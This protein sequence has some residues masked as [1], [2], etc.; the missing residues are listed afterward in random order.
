ME[1][2]LRKIL[3]IFLFFIS[4]MMNSENKPVRLNI[5]LNDSITKEDQWLYW[6]SENVL[7]DSF[8]V[9]KGQKLLELNGELTFEEGYVSMLIFE[10]NGP[11]SMLV[12]NHGDNI[13]VDF[14]KEVLALIPYT[15]NSVTRELYEY[16][17]HIRPLNICI[18]RIKD[19]LDK[20]PDQGWARDS[21]NYYITQRKDLSIDLLKMTKNPQIYVVYMDNAVGLDRDSLVSVLKE[22]FPDS[23]IAQQY[24]EYPQEYKDIVKT[25]KSFG[26]RLNEINT[27]KKNRS[28]RPTTQKQADN[29]TK[30]NKIK[31]GD[32]I[33]NIVLNDIKE[34]PVS[35]ED[36]K[37]PYILIDFWAAWCAPCRREIPHL[38][39]VYD[40]FKEKLTIYAISLD[41]TKQIWENTILSDKCEMFTHVYGGNMTTLEGKDICNRFG[42]TA[43]PANFLL[44]NDRKVIATNL[45]GEEL[46]KKMEELIIE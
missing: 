7:I 12:L 34:N 36:I 3:F 22:R 44:D 29:L 15:Q 8:M 40:L 39:K 16:G 10:K 28:I 2:I 35:L 27:L 17:L 30:Y 21:L 5:I 26:R 24:P 41:N 43:I 32:M 4:V 11:Q 6:T 18:K 20:S 9:K 31:L 25:K 38:K 45:R 19:I 46:M 14:T 42:I 23:K 37:T 1:I 33:D 13:T